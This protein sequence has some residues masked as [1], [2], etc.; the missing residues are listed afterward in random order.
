MKY[1]ITLTIESEVEDPSEILDF[2]N[3]EVANMVPEYLEGALVDASV[4]PYLCPIATAYLKLKEH[5]DAQKE[6]KDVK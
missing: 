2:F 5:K 1:T 3:E 6:N 4:E